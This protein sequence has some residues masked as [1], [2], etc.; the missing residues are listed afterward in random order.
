MKRS[1]ETVASLPAPRDELP[2][3]G[4]LFG[5]QSID[6]CA[7]TRGGVAT[8]R[9]GLT[10]ALLAAVLALRCRSLRRVAVIWFAPS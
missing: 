8:M 5:V 4:V 1:H 7:S 10:G 3:G 9:F 2:L 6:P